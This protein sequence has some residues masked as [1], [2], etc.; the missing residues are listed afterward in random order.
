MRLCKKTPTDERVLRNNLALDS[1][2]RKEGGHNRSLDPEPR[3][4]NN[5]RLGSSFQTAK[6]VR[7]EIP[8]RGL[9]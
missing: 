5:L 8:H 1:G 3:P 2:N 9:E 7:N 6:T 4:E